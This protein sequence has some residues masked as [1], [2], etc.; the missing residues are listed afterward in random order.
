MGNSICI[1]S[2]SSSQ[3]YVNIADS[4]EA[5]R[6]LDD[7]EW[8][9]KQ[10]NSYNSSDTTNNNSYKSSLSSQQTELVHLRNQSK[11]EA[12]QYTNLVAE[13]LLLIQKI[14]CED[15]KLIELNSYLE[16]FE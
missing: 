6:L 16:D 11:Q 13:N 2:S 8:Y 4:K 12:V 15:N 10:A 9:L 5:K 14:S 7:Y 3:T 1:S